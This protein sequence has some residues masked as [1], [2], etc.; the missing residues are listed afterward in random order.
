MSKQKKDCGYPQSFYISQ[1]HRSELQ[2]G[3]YKRAVKFIRE[4]TD[5]TWVTGIAWNR[6]LSAQ[7]HNPW[8][9]MHL[10]AR[11]GPLEP[12]QTRRVMGRIW[13]LKGNKDDLLSRYQQWKSQ[14]V[15]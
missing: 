15:K 10:S 11:V 9:C 1:Y 3:T 8:E 2:V 12:L 7:G 5:A 4:S 13:L 14:Q 6:F